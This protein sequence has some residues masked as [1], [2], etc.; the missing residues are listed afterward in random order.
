M[1]GV[2]PYF[3]RLYNNTKATSEKF[4]FINELLRLNEQLFGLNDTFIV[5]FVGIFLT[6]KELLVIWNEG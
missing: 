1:N 6:A 3:A 4:C 2:Y 5:L